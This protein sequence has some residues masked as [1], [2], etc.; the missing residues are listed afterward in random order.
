MST[1]EL[2]LVAHV[3]LAIL[4]IGPT[5]VA[6]SA[7]PRHAAAAEPGDRRAALRLHRICRQYGTLTIGV[8]AAGAALVAELGVWS[9]VW[10]QAAI[11][12]YLAGLLVLFVGVLP[13]QRRLLA[14]DE[15]GHDR[16]EVGRLHGVTGLYSLT[17][18]A[19]L[20][21]MIVKP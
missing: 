17:W 9:E 20:V 8:G 14:S 12:T 6:G 19:T 16:A 13:L 4:S 3:F 10:V 2:L 7:F 1:S 15:A 21:L 5:T 18:S 11:G